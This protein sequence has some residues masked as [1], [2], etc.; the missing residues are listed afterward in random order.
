MI[1]NKLT[2]KDIAKALNLSQ[3]TISRALKDSYNISEET[4]KLVQEYARVH[5][6][7]PNIM[8]QGLKNKNSRCIGVVLCNIPN[9]FFAEVLSGIESVAYQKDYFVFITQSQE[10]I[11]KERKNVDNL[12]FRS[13][14]GLLVSLSSES[15]DVSHFIHLHEQGLPIVFF[16][17]I[18]DAIN[19]HTV[20]ADN[21]GGAYSGTEHL[22]KMGFH[23]IAHITSSRHLSITKERLKG[24]ENA[25]QKYDIKHNDAYIKYCD[26]GGMLFEEIEKAVSEL[27][28]LPDPPKAILTASD[29]ITIGCLSILQKKGISIPKEIALIGFSNFSSPELFSPPLSTIKQPAFEMGKTAA[30]LLIQLIESKKK[31]DFKKVV[32]PTSLNIQR[33]SR[34]K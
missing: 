17:R 30:E 14:D 11:E 9:S 7:H 33:S 32:L 31:V 26:H 12:T 29:R 1:H 2:I 34:K 19:T 8:A 13:V 27:L 20:I 5:D 15:Q 22:I 23:K 24:Y 10:S 3:S 16:D 25:L 18:T 21:E 28:S 6:Y 4:R